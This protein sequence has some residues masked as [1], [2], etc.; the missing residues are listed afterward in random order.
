MFANLY[1]RGILYKRGFSSWENVR[2]RK[3]VL[4]VKHNN[5]TIKFSNGDT[6][7]YYADLDGPSSWRQP[8]HAPFKEDAVL[9]VFFGDRPV[10]YSLYLNDDANNAG[11]QK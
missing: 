1:K 3:M 11:Q 9:Q 7:V 8:P 2:V 10:W 5:M 4:G 6:V